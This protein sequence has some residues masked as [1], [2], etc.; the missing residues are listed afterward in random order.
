LDGNNSDSNSS[1]EIKQ[2]AH[3]RSPTAVD[4]AD[5]DLDGKINYEEFLAALHP[6][7]NEPNVPRPLTPSQSDTAESTYLKI[8]VSHSNVVDLS[9][10]S[11]YQPSVDKSRK[12]TEGETDSDEEIT[13]EDVDEKKIKKISS[14]TAE[15]E[16][17]GVVSMF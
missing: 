15:Q 3:L 8:F 9:K 5:T 16:F 13:V 2:L 10:D 4:W 17:S 7:F 12:D 14:E 6:D 11:R 1:K